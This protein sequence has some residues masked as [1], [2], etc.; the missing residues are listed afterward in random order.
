VKEE[1]RS[2]TGSGAHERAATRKAQDGRRHRP[3]LRAPRDGSGGE[4][5]RFSG[6]T[7]A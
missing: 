6:I 5:A 2:S 1:E 4:S 7:R 3:G